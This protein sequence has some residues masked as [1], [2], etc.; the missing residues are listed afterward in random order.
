MPQLTPKWLSAIWGKGVA[1]CLGVE[2]DVMVRFMQLFQRQVSRVK[3]V[4]EE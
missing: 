4:L 1:A 2:K 3:W